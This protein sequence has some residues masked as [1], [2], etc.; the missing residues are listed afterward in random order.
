M[1]SQRNIT[2]GVD[3]SLSH[4]GRSSTDRVLNS[5]ATGLVTENTENELN[6]LLA[7][8]QV[9]SFRWLLFGG[10]TEAI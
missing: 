9:S 3:A 2:S 5:N 1:I 10:L 7:Q 4:D 6:Q 8:S